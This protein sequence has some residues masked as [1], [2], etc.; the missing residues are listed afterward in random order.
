MLTP[1]TE[2][3]WETPKSLRFDVCQENKRREALLPLKESGEL[4]TPAW[5]YGGGLVSSGV[6]AAVWRSH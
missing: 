6:T 5:R 4:F 3:A 1:G 2:L